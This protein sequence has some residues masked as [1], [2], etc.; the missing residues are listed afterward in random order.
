MVQ[1]PSKIVPIPIRQHVITINHTLNSDNR[2]IKLAPVV[3]AS[4]QLTLDRVHLLPNSNDPRSIVSERDANCF[5]TVQVGSYPV[6]KPGALTI[7]KLFA[8]LIAGLTARPVLRVRRQ[9]RTLQVLRR[10]LVISFL[11]CDSGSYNW[12]ENMRGSTR[13]VLIVDREDEVL[14]IL[15]TAL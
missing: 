8:I 15:R 4:F 6:K 12:R 2:V 1:V 7:A 3:D 10:D 9:A 11:P 13:I 5:G 14:K